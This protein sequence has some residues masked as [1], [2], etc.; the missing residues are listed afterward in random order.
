MKSAAVVIFVLASSAGLT[1]AQNN[2]CQT[3]QPVSI[4]GS[5]PVMGGMIVYDRSQ[6]VC[7]LADANLAARSNPSG[8]LRRRR[9]QSKWLDGLRRSAEMGRGAEYLR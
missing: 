5:P 6:G 4:L 8:E 1:F 3:T 2:P 9:H 7:W